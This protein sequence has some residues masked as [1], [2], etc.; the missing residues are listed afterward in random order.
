MTPEEKYAAQYQEW[1]VIRDE[2]IAA[3]LSKGE[4]VTAYQVTLEQRKR[5]L[6]R[7][8]RMVTYAD[9]CKEAPPALS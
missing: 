3:A 5:L 4:A 7:G 2:M 9:L 6:A 8:D 1:C